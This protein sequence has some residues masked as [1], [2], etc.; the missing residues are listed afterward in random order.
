[1]GYSLCGYISKYDGNECKDARCKNVIVLSNA[2]DDMPSEPL[3]ITVY[4]NPAPYDGIYIKLGGQATALSASMY[5]G[6]G[7]IVAT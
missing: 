4:P 5:D 3:D 2:V 6:H 7:R 1:M